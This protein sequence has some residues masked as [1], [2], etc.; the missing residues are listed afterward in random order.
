MTASMLMRLLEGLSLDGLYDGVGMH[1]VQ[2]VSTGR[3]GASKGEGYITL[4][5]LRRG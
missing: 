3:V 4:T 1:S 2:P 5:M